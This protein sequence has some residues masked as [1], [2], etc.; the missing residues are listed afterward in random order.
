MGQITA[1]FQTSHDGGW[2]PIPI[3]FARREQPQ[4][5]SVSTRPISA[6]DMDR[7]GTPSRSRYAILRARS[8]SISE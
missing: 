2:S 5:H 7:V 4:I 6:A 8:R 1:P 3:V